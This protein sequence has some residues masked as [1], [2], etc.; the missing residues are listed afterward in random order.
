LH[1]DAVEN[2]GVEEVDAGV[3]AVAH[4]H[5]HIMSETETQEQASD[6]RL[7]NKAVD[8]ARLFV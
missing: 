8:L 7:L 6:L 5:L 4:K 1:L 2:R 3:D